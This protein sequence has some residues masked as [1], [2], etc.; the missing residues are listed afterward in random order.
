MSVGTNHSFIYTV[1]GA[2]YYTKIISTQDN[3]IKKN[4]YSTVAMILKGGGRYFGDK[5]LVKISNEFDTPTTKP[6]GL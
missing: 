1:E 6:Y 2:D 3:F 5:G 4:S